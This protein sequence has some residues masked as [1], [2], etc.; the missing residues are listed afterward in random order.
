MSEAGWNR[1]S[2]RA[3][4]CLELG[5]VFADAFQE[6]DPGG[7]RLWR[8][9][10][11]CCA[12]LRIEGGADPPVREKKDGLG[13]TDAAVVILSGLLAIWYLALDRRTRIGLTAPAP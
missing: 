4:S 5:G 11:K 10:A 8:M 9:D 13:D 7:G 1:V 6:P 3:V 12:H 2:E